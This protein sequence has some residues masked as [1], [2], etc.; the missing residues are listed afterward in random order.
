MKGR[1]MFDISNDKDLNELCDWINIY[2][3]SLELI[4]SFY[5]CYMVVEF[6]PKTVSK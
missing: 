6:E 3:A 1:I 5:G 4:M 2:Q